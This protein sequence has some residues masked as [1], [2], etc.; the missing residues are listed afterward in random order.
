MS[1]DSITRYYRV[2]PKEIGYIGYTVHAYE[3]IGVVRTLDPS[4]GIIEILISSDF[5]DEMDA[6]LQDLRREVPIEE[7]DPT[8]MVSV[9]P[10]AEGYGEKD[11]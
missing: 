5:I 1:L 11:R 2:D 6:L 7:I 9:A 10:E 3:G 8:G 4:Q